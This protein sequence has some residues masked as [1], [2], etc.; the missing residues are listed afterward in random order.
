MKFSIPRNS[1]S[2]PSKAKSEY[3]KIQIIG[4]I[5]KIKNPTTQGTSIAYACK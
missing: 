1:A 2:Y 3:R 4:Y 5:V